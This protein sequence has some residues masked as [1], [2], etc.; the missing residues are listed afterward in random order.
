MISTSVNKLELFSARAVERIPY[1]QYFLFGLLLPLGFAPFH[2]PGFTLLGLALFYHQLNSRKTKSPFFSGLFFGLGF[3][4]L[5]TSWIYVSIHDYGHLSIITAGFIT[6][7]FLL[8]ISC[9][10]ALL[11]VIFCRLL[12]KPYTLGASLLFSSLWL[13]SEYLRATLLSG[14]PWLLIGFGQIDAPTRFLLP[15]LGVFGVG[16]L[17]CLAATLLSNIIQKNRN[18]KR[19]SY[20]L[21]FI[22]IIGCPVL[23]KDI[24]WAAVDKQPIS[25]GVIQANLS[26][27]DKWD[28]TLFWQL[29]ERYQNAAK[30]LLGTQ[31]IVM[32]ESAIPLPPTYISDFLD[33]LNDDA[34]QAGS[35]ILLGIPQPTSIDESSYFNSLISLGKAKGVYLKQHLVPFGEY[36]PP[37]FQFII[38]KLGIPDPNMKPGQSNQRLIQVHHHPIA[39]LICYEIAYGNL[40]REQL[41]TAEWIVSISDDGWFGHSLALYQQLQMAQV[42]SLQAARY[43][44]VA[45]NDGLSAVIDTQGKIE[46]FLPAY[47]E[48]VLKAAIFSATGKTPWVTLGDLPALVFGLLIILIFVSYHLMFAKV[49]TQT[50][51]AKHKRRYP[52]QPS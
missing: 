12:I 6:F 19:Y 43:Q 3:F 8:Y 22:I 29:L 40:L 52:Y 39:T 5:G 16:F 9:F 21:L 36:I 2:L 31:L 51:A 17:T 1:L 10:P 20:L 38:N 46:N 26:M 27:R 45:N 37:A 32:P 7:L 25:V 15:I 50:I 14:F 18:Y 47:S 34:K 24:N 35:A 28:E 30:S 49:S 42:R 23:L 48:G 44:I 4:G 11:S 13:G 33:S 41:P